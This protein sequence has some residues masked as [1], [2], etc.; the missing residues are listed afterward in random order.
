MDFYETVLPALRECIYNIR[1][2]NAAKRLPE[3]DS[4]ANQ[5]LIRPSL[6]PSRRFVVNA[7]L[8]R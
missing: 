2:D 4:P 7:P 8:K 6:N 3:D 5:D 1:L